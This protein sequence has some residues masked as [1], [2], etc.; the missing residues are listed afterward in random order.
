LGGLGHGRVVGDLLLQ[1]LLDVTVLDGGRHVRIADRNRTRAT[2][3]TDGLAGNTVFSHLVHQRA[4]QNK[5][6]ELVNLR[7]LVAW[8]RLLPGRAPENHK[9]FGSRNQWPV[10][11]GKLP[12]RG[13]R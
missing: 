5:I 8:R 1:E 11:I 12:T 9:H 4:G 7:N 3:V 13:C 2:A 10:A 6:E